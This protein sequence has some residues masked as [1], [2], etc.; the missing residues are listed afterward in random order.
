VASASATTAQEI[1]SA[2]YKDYHRENET[3]EKTHKINTLSLAC[4]YRIS[5][6]IV[7]RQL[8]NEFLDYATR[9]MREDTTVDIC[10]DEYEGDGT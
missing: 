1:L 10:D 5:A 8:R 4:Y 9:T 7:R 3:E 2:A 6:L